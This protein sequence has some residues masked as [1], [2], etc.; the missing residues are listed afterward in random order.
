MR[1]KK[2]DIP[3]QKICDLISKDEELEIV[4]R[5]GI[6]FGQSEVPNYGMA[7][8]LAEFLITYYTP[9]NGLVLDQFSGR[10]TIGAAA[11]FHGRRFVGYDLNPKNVDRANEVFSKHLCHD[12]S[13][14]VFVLFRWCDP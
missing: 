2:A 8:D 12:Q 14:F 3:L 11:L 5:R 13:R 9:K 10:F 4:K 1:F 6:N 7:A